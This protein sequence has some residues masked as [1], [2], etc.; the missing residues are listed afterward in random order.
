[1]AQHRGHNEGTISKRV[2]TRKDGTKV[3]RYIAL[4]P[5]DSSGQRPSV[6]SFG[7]IREA[8]EAL[9]SGKVA[10]AQGIVVTGKV[11]TVKEWC[12]QWFAGRTRIGYA[13]RRGYRVS[14][15]TVYS[16]IGLIRLT[17]LTEQHIAAMW[18]KLERG[19]AADGS[20]VPPL[21]LTTIQKHHTR[22]KAALNAAVASRHVQLTY[23]PA[24]S[25]QARPGKGARKQINPLSED[26]ARAFM[27]AV[28]DTPDAALFT[29]L[30]TTGMRLGEAQALRWCDVD[31]DRSTVGIRQSIH[32]ET[33]T[34]WVAGET[35]TGRSRLVSIPPGTVAALRKQRARQNEMRLAAGPTW[36]DNDYVF[37]RADGRPL[38]AVHIRNAMVRACDAAGIARRSVKDL[39]H[40]YATLALTR[41]VPLK[42]VSEA[43][44]HA[45]VAITAD[46]YSHV[47]IG[48]QASYMSNLE[49][50]FS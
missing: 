25:E 37:T 27:A 6:G 50:L 24:K 32:F 42:V 8:R 26:E 22:L 13:T 11:P 40:T 18:S 34:G 43:L 36:Q 15:D 39:R 48:L 17:D 1:M 29:T 14:L 3:T 23:N 35:K 12:E 47:T 16:Y 28:A 4:M 21:A 44:G 19:I 9:S 33:G 30:L 31:L 20:S 49:A 46:T 38:P 41:N 7:T 2:I 5:A 45:S 10:R